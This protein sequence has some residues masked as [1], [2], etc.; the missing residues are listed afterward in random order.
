MPF[1]EAEIGQVAEMVWESVLGL[2]LEPGGDVP[3]APE[4]VVS[5]LVQV[6]GAWEGAV[7][8]E[9]S[10]DFA[11][12]A[13]AIMF[14]VPAE[15]VSAADTVDALGELVNMTGGNI[16][17]LLAEPCRLSLPSVAEGGDLARGI[18]GGTLVTM[19]AFECLGTPLVVRLHRKAEAGAGA[20]VPGRREFS[21]VA[22]HLRA[23]VAGADPPVHQG[24]I[25]NL[26]LKGGFFRTDAP[27]VPGM[28]CHVRVYL[29]GT[30]IEVRADGHVVRPGEGG[31]AIQFEE[32]VGVDSL[33]HLRNLILF[34]TTDPKQVE[35]EFHDHLGLRRA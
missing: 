18:P 19:L 14:G 16:K 21:R 20:P 12:A 25:E 4:R 23:E 3:P 27:L 31:Y 22:I 7:T 29:E 15:A 24:T 17:A 26:S 8:I 2:R 5:A 11:H 13:A 33:E 28:R 35:Q 1:L 30:G 34:N 10:A 9:C 32:I 6:S